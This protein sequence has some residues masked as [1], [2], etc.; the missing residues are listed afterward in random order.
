MILE[1]KHQYIC[2]EPDAAL[3][4]LFVLRKCLFGKF[5]LG[6]CLNSCGQMLLDRA[7]MPPASCHLNNIMLLLHLSGPKK[8]LRIIFGIPY[9][10]V[11]MFKLVMLKLIS[12]AKD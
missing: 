8:R 5:A 1:T 6:L 3:S 11:V 7:M 12:V 2:Q 4:G 9:S 10:T